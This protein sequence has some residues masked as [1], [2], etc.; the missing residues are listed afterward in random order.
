MAAP[1]HFGAFG[2]EPRA[3]LKS[4]WQHARPAAQAL[5]VLPMEVL[6]E[7]FWKLDPQR[8]IGKFADFADMK[9]E[10]ADVFVTL[11]DW[12][13]DGPPLAL[14][15]ARELFESFFGANAPGNGKWQVC[16]APA[17]PSALGVPLL[18]IVSTSDRIVP[19]QSA[20]RA[21]EELVV[22]QGHVGMV[23]GSKRMETLWQPL[24]QWLSRRDHGC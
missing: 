10:S 20:A 8:T 15:A 2:D 1:W 19:R 18:N 13:N 21:G 3:S 4:L 9:G 14:A 12:A 6:Q 17:D 23:V 5:G 22:A 16:G 7:A 24:L 11:E